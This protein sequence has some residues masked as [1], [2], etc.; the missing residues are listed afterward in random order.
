MSYFSDQARSDSVEVIIANK[1]LDQL[2]AGKVFL[3][4]HNA[5]FI[6]PALSGTTV[7]TTFTIINGGGLVTTGAPDGAR[8]GGKVR[9]TVSPNA[10][11]RISGV[12][13]TAT[14]NKDIVNTAATSEIHDGVEISM[15]SSVTW[16]VRHIQGIWARQA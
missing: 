6:L 4:K 11:D 5:T 10:S 7:G 15:S 14:D 1:T 3:V 9:I 8:T 16:I 12:D 13:L 2:D